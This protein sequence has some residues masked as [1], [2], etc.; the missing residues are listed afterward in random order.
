[1][2]YKLAS[3]LLYEEWNFY[4][5]GECNDLY[6]VHQLASFCVNVDH[7]FV[8]HDVR[9]QCGGQNPVRQRSIVLYNL[10]HH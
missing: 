3:K 6:N 9:C 5:A 1:M 8:R 10:P 2:H 4:Y 7:G